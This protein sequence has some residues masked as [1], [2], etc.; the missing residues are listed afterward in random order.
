MNLCLGTVQFGMDY[1]VQDQGR[2]S[3]I[4]ANEMLTFAFNKGIH[5]FDTASA[6]GN[7]ETVLGRFI[8]KN[9]K[10]V[11][12]IQIVS[13]IPPNAL[14]NVSDK[15]WRDTVLYHAEHSIATLGIDRLYAYLFHNARYIFEEK[16][17]EALLSVTARG[18]AEKIGVSVYTP[19]EAMKALEYNEIKVIQ[20]PYNVFDQRLDQCSFFQKAKKK[21]VEIY[22]R[23]TLL[24]GLIMMEPDRLPERMRF[25]SGYLKQF[26]DICSEYGIAPLKAAVGYV[27]ASPDIDYMVFGADNKTQLAECI[28]MQEERIPAGMVSD[29]RAAFEAVEE[30]LVNP[31]LWNG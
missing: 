1:G 10:N 20:V 25:A 16:A 3:E 11:D 17:V 7:A 29:L 5:C 27:G 15:T 12:G 8:G 21:G 31:V 14:E 26:L 28:S 9:K 6:Y 2:P 13:K 4:L 18:F 23:S 19:E 30:K 22:A 24:Q